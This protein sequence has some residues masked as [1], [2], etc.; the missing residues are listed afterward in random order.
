[1]AFDGLCLG[2]L[3]MRAYGVVN[4]GH[5]TLLHEPLQLHLCHHQRYPLTHVAT[6]ARNRIAAAKQ[7]VDGGDTK[8]H[9]AVAHA[10]GKSHELD[11]LSFLFFRLQG[12]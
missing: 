2:Y 7:A 5:Y 4:S 11:P 9:W 10:R 12:W 8:Q 3:E 6:Q 1:M